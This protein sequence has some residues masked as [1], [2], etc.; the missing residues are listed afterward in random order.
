MRLTE[1]K[2]ARKKTV[3]RASVFHKFVIQI[4]SEVK[5]EHGMSCSFCI[6]AAVKLRG[7]MLGATQGFSRGLEE[8]L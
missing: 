7:C 4:R 3:W 1:L 8:P 6:Q 2:R 5:G